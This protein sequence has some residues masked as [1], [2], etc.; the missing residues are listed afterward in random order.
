MPASISVAGADLGDIG[1]RP[2]HPPLAPAAAV[3]AAEQSA[4][5]HV[6]RKKFINFYELN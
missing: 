4:Q 5:A 3:L 1:V 6:A 2:C